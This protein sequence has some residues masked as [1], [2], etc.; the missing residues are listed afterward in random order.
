[1]NDLVAAAQAYRAERSRYWIRRREMG[2]VTTPGGSTSILITMVETEAG[3]LLFSG[4][5][6][7][8][9]AWL[10]QK[11]LTEALRRLLCEPSDEMSRLAG[12]PTALPAIFDYLSTEG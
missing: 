10:D 6:D 5:E 4:Q 2:K 8:A 12:S 7:A 1:M 9:K 11:C 3:E